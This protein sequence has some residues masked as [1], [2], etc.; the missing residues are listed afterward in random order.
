M[1]NGFQGLLEN[2]LYQIG[3]GI[4]AANSPLTPAGQAIGRGLLLGQAELEKA[5]AAKQ[6]RAMREL[7]QQRI[8]Q[9]MEEARIEQEYRQRFRERAPDTAR[10]LAGA[11]PEGPLLPSEEAQVGLLSEAFQINP[12]LLPQMLHARAQQ[13]AP[14]IPKKV[15]EYEHLKGLVGKDKAADLIWGAKVSGTAAERALGVLRDTELKR[16]SGQQPTTSE[17]MNE[18]NA[19]AILGTETIVRG[20]QGEIVGVGKTPLPPYATYGAAGVPAQQ[21]TGMPAESSV[22]SA[23][24]GRVTQIRGKRMPESLKKS[25]DR[26]AQ[27][28]TRAVSVYN[29]T[30]G[31]PVSRATTY[32]P[33]GAALA[34]A[35]GLLEIAGM[36]R[37]T[38]SA[39]LRNSLRTINLELAPLAMHEEGRGIA[40]EERAKL[41]EL[42]GGVTMTTGP[43]DIVRGLEATVRYLNQ[44]ED[45]YEYR[46]SRNPQTGNI[47]MQRRAK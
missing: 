28:V 25:A 29:A 43:S 15:A 47:E 41:E 31:D 7:E 17:L 14:S 2:P 24:G 23:P 33:G 8:R 13:K 18:Q 44:M 36:E 22:P 6:Q 27:E 30:A 5:Q 46:L 45:R 12:N 26:V 32:G 21:P 42:L 35:G 19:K 39:E 4:L 20:D 11:V 37:P 9:K 16:Q 34:G 1:A 38:A 10:A 3:A 40:K